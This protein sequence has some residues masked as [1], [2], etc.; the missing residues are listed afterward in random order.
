ML[1]AYELYVKHKDP[2][3]TKKIE[4]IQYAK[5]LIEVLFKGLMAVL[6]I[7]LF[8][9]RTSKETMKLDFETRV[10]LYLFGFIL[11][12]TAD[13]KSIIH[14][15]PKSIQIAQSLVGRGPSSK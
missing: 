3:N 1:A 8:N 15:V 4:K 7:M 11:L 10:L 14:N 12:L 2:K 9:P 13:W 6:L 5:D